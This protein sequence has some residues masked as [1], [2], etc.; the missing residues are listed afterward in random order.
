MPL[1]ASNLEALTALPVAVSQR[2]DSVRNLASQLQAGTIWRSPD[3]KLSVTFT[4]AQRSQLES[5]V[6]AYLD[7]SE[8]IITA[9]R[10]MLSAAG[11]G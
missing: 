10:A 1:T 4:A 8:T 6:T 3:G 2:Q 7:E 9:A 11:D 5:I